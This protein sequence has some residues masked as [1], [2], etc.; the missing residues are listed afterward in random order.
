MAWFEHG[1]AR[2]YHEESGVGDPLL[3]LPGWG[4]SIEELAPLTAALATSYRVIAADLPGSGK[5]EPQPRTFTPSYFGDDAATLLAMLDA[6][7]ARPA[8]L[9]GF[10]DGGEC[11]LLMAATRPEAVRSL[12]TWGAAGSLGTN[13]ELAD[14]MTRLIDD[15][16]P[17]MVGF[18]EFLKAAH[19]EEHARIMTR[20]AGQSFRTIMEAGGDISRSRAGQITAPALLITGEHDFLATPQLVASM[21]A[22]IPNGTFMQAD[23]ASH[24]VHHEQPEWLVRTVVDWLGERS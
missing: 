4:G 7:E 20:S 8:H 1:D 24:P 23:G 14:A 12:V 3:L 18:A 9:V 11:A 16:I 22:A 6:L 10:S 15:P 17:P 13:I 19:G 21:A 5:S 2:V